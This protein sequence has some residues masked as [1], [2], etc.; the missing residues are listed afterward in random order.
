LAWYSHSKCHKTPN[1]PSVHTYGISLSLSEFLNAHF[2]FFFLG[3]RFVISFLDSDVQIV[4][5]FFVKNLKISIMTSKANA[6]WQACCNLPYVCCY[7][8]LCYR[9]F[10][11][12]SVF[13]AYQKMNFDPIQYCAQVFCRK[14]SERGCTAIFFIFPCTV[15]GMFLRCMAL[16]FLCAQMFRW[17]QRFWALVRNFTSMG[18]IF[19]TP[20]DKFLESA[21]LSKLNSSSVFAV[22]YLQVNMNS[23]YEHGCKCHTSQR[24]HLFVV[25]SVCCDVLQIVKH[26]KSVLFTAVYQR[27]MCDFFWEVLCGPGS[28]VE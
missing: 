23:V 10:L 20:A 3:F 28:V 5:R 25:K 11:M 16:L 12:T 19:Y 18:Q 22:C 6:Y 24:R 2:S 9:T 4:L 14:T 1:H 15:P 13:A 21:E 17:G 27:Y 8:T 7:I 26:L